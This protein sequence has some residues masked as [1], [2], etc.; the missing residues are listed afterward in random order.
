[1]KNFVIMSNKSVLCFRSI[2][3]GYHHQP[4]NKRLIVGVNL[5][6]RLFVNCH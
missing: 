3:R 1:M 5:M 4:R 6:P 2:V